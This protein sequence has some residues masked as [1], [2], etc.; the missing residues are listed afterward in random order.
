MLINTKLPDTYWGEAAITA[1]YLQN[2][3]PCRDKTSTPFELLYNKKPNVDYLKEFGCKA[4]AHISKQNRKK[5]DS[6]ARECILVG[7]SHDSK[8]YRLL[9]RSSG[10]IIISRDV[11][12]FE[13]SRV[14]GQNANKTEIKMDQHLLPTEKPNEMVYIP[15]DLSCQVPNNLEDVPLSKRI[16][17]LP[18]N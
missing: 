1:T 3:L 12:F 14:E 11:K 7:Y 5:L 8:G 15:F 13:E 6:K 16:Q 10:K 9:E 18:V 17:T 4:Y 2:R